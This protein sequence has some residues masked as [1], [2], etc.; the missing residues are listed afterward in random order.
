M[1][2]LF[3]DP[4][5]C[6]N[7]HATDNACADRF[8]S[9]TRSSNVSTTNLDDS[10]WESS[11]IALSSGWNL[12]STSNPSNNILNQTQASLLTP[13]LSSALNNSLSWTSEVNAFMSFTFEGNYLA[14]YA[15]LSPMVGSFVPSI[16]GVAYPTVDAAKNVG[17]DDDITGGQVVWSVSGLGEGSHEVSLRNEGRGGE[18]VMMVDYVQWATVEKMCVSALQFLPPSFS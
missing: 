4:P 11:T 8:S 7:F 15:P 13:L 5:P 14:L 9:S 10:A 12:M 3:L 18:G 1:R 6:L 17:L 16:D 2:S